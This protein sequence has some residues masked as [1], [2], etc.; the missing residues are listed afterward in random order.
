MFK[1]NHENTKAVEHEMFF[2]DFV[3]SHFRA[4][5]VNDSLANASSLNESV[6]NIL[7]LTIYNLHHLYSINFEGSGGSATRALPGKMITVEVP[8]AKTLS[9]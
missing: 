4:F 3:F 1:S 8:W 6:K 5:G 7:Y 9:C 2:A